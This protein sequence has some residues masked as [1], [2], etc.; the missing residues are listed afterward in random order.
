MIKSFK[1]L[2]GILLGIAF[3]VLVWA[4]RTGKFEPRSYQD[5]GKLL[6]VTSDAQWPQ[7]TATVALGVYA[8]KIYDFAVQS[9]S[10]S[11]EGWV[12]LTWS[13]DFQDLLDT[14]KIPVGG[15]LNVPNMV[16]TSNFAFTPASENPIKLPDGRY[17]QTFKYYGK[18]YANGLNFRRF[19]FG[20]LSF[21]LTFSLN[22]ENPLLNSG[23]VRLVP[24]KSQ[25]GLGQ[26]TE[27]AGYVLTGKRLGEYL[28]EFQ[29][30]FGLPMDHAGPENR[31]G[32]VQMEVIYNPSVLSALLQLFLPL[33]VVMAVVLLAPNL[34]GSL[35]DVRVALPSTALLTLI[36]LQQ[37]YRTQLPPL[38][39]LTFIDQVYT[40]CYATALVI[41]A[42]FVWSSNRLETAA[43][44][45]RSAVLAQIKRIDRR[46]QVGL[47]ISLVTL[48]CLGW[49]FPVR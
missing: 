13:Q 43:E 5:K 10:F 15:V 32:R 3:I 34:A 40:L 26:Y 29:T 31:F 27:I 12:W 35:W 23:H 16:Q 1:S 49:L 48:I 7:K 22:P 41:F 24:D 9:Q 21:P 4:N 46:F 8:E 30:R 28:Y 25:S 33:V 18:F 47:S 11:S 14:G 44:A 39:Y 42:L 37:G 2:G 38:P 20:S 19:P 6:P 36:F 17:C 45:D